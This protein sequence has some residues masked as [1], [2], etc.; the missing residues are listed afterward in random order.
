[1][2]SATLPCLLQ[3]CV[4]TILGCTH[5]RST[6]RPLDPGMNGQA[7]SA[8]EGSTADSLASCTWV[9]VD[10]ETTL[11]AFGIPLKS[12]LREYDTSLYYCCPGKEGRAPVCFQAVWGLQHR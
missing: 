4:A 10:E 9:V 11:K 7:L 1:M 12:E 6:V 3:L 2:R 8:T 5:T